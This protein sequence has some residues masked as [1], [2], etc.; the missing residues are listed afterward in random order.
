MRALRPERTFPRGPATAWIRTAR[1]ASIKR[2]ARSLAPRRFLHTDRA[3][4]SVRTSVA[5]RA[6]SLSRRYYLDVRVKKKSKKNLKPKSTLHFP[7]PPP[8]NTL[9]YLYTSRRV[10]RRFFRVAFGVSFRILFFSTVIFAVD[11]DP[12]EFR[13]PTWTTGPGIRRLT[14]RTRVITIIHEAVGVRPELSVFFF[15]IYRL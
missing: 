10:F 12:A 1:A 15:V 2:R 11:I 4:P 13:I 6:P 3:S 14:S 9:F 8:A 5:L 7:R